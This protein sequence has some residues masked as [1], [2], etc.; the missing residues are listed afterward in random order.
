MA[1]SKLKGFSEEGGINLDAWLPTGCNTLGY[2]NMW[3]VRQT[4][5]QTTGLTQLLDH[6][7]NA[8]LQS[9]IFTGQEGSTML[10]DGEVSMVMHMAERLGCTLVLQLVK[11]Q[12]LIDLY[13]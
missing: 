13:G 6:G 5:R 7:G 3:S 1:A 8:L 12:G 10:K 2:H 4:R 11:A 9:P